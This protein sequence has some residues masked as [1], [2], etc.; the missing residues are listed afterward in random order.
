M[1]VGIP[2]GLLYYKYHPFLITFFSELGAEIITSVNTNKEVLD[3]GVKYCVDEACLPIKIF[4]GHI[5]FLKDKCDIIV[6]PRLMQLH[7]NEYICPKFCGL[8]EMVLNSIPNMPKTITAPI[9]ASSKRKLYYWAKSSGKLF[10]K[11]NLKIK[12]AFMKALDKQEKHKT[13]INDKKYELKVALSG[14]PYNIYDNYVNM[15]VIKKLN[16]L[17]VGVITEEYMDTNLINTEAKNLYKK[18]FW[19][20][21][22][23]N[24]GFTVN[25]SKNKEVGGIVY[26][27]SFNCGIDSVI[28]ELIKDRICDFPFLILK[29]DEQ[30]GEAGINTRLEAFVDMLERRYEIESNISTNG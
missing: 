19:T 5:S 14:H 7:K 10:T 17:G 13:G 1:K 27:S 29:I 26:I 20:F 6:I 9:Y 28:V 15:N 3:A 18:P 25:A 23:N 30:T 24:Y 11:N 16:N 22:R 21:A 2:Q 8:P 12:G 4:H